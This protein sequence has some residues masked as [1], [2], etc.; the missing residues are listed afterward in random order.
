MRHHDNK[1]KL[2]RET[3]QRL[4]L[5]RGLAVS[6]VRDG[7]IETT[8]AKAKEL[9]PFIEKLV[10]RAK[11]GT[12]SGERLIATRLSSKISANKLVKTIAP[13]MKSR[14]GGYTRITKLA[15]RSSDQSLMA[16]IEFVD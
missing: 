12:P 5:L 10:T 8:L 1:R 2:S 15:P 13:K 9:R 6:L 3:G 4:A 11:G 16:V 7:K 14:V